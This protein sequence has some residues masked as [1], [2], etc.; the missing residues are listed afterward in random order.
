M[1]VDDT[2]DK[3]FIN[4]LDEE[5]AL[6]DQEPDQDRLIFLPDIDRHLNRIPERLLRPD[7]VMV[8]DENANFKDGN[9]LVLY[10]IPESLTVP[11]ERDG[12][13]KAIIE[14]RRRAEV[15][16]QKHRSETSG[17]QYREIESSDM[18]LDNAL[19]NRL[20]DDEDAMD[21]E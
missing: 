18:A 17:N 19:G 16:A 20:A 11:P 4:N 14:S 3:M 5:L 12:V 8:E 9:Q 2:P 10:R 21:I 15:E 6:I 7:R 13:R 1:A